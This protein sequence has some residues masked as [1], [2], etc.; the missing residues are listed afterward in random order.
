[1]SDILNIINNIMNELDNEYTNIFSTNILDFKN[2]LYE[3]M[4][5]L[6]KSH[7]YYLDILVNKYNLEKINFYTFILKIFKLKN[8]LNNINLINNY[9]T[10]YNK[11][12]K[13]IPTAG[14]IILYNNNILLVKIK[15]SNKYGL[16]KGKKEKNESIYDTAIR[17]VNEETGLNIC[18]YIH[19]KF[20]YVNILNTKFYIINLKEKINIFNNFDKNEIED[21]QWFDIDY[22]KSN[23]QLFTKQTK[24]I[25][26]KF[27]YIIKKKYNTTFFNYNKNIN[28]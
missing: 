27:N 28:Y 3:N 24:I 7:W 19:D 12:K 15:N 4:K 8:M 13:K 2:N 23:K 5:L 20:I 26:F 17:E 9:I 25:A 18:S 22:I 10:T 6:E 1:M 14:G 21:I 11:Y 16:P